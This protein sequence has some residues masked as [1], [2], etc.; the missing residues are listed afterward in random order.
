[1]PSKIRKQKDALQALTAQK[2]RRKTYP[3]ARVSFKKD[4]PLPKA[5]RIALEGTE[6]RKPLQ[7][8]PPDLL[9]TT[10][11]F[12]SLHFE[13]AEP[14]ELVALI[15]ALKKREA[16][17]ARVV[18]SQC[19]STMS[20]VMERLE[21]FVSEAYEGFNK[22]TSHYKQK[23]SELDEEQAVTLKRLRTGFDKYQMM[24]GTMLESLDKIETQIGRARKDFEKEMEKMLTTHR[25]ERAQLKAQTD[26]MCVNYR[27]R[28]SGAIKVGC[29]YDA[30]VNPVFS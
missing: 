15:D 9:A 24:T 4:S 1:M 5:R 6:T 26:K 10:S 18:D 3:I 8:I 17:V 2:A 28:V 25:A 29:V 16:G 12:W 21:G 20:D 19:E 7:S 30:F 13:F 22:T 27:K 23:T 11:R 14:E